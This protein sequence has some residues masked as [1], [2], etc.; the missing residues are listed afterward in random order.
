MFLRFLLSIVF[1][2]ASAPHLLSVPLKIAIL[3]DIHHNN[4]QTNTSP[5]FKTM[6]SK[7][8]SE[9][10]SHIIVTGDLI[11]R[12]VGGIK[13]KEVYIQYF[14]ELADALS[15]THEQAPADRI[16]LAIG[17]HDFVKV[18]KEEDCKSILSEF[19]QYLSIPENYGPEKGLL[20]YDFAVQLRA[21]EKHGPPGYICMPGLKSESGF[22]SLFRKNVGLQ[23]F[24]KQVKEQR[25]YF[26][27]FRIGPYKFRL[28]HVPLY[29]RKKHR[30]P[31][32]ETDTHFDISGDTHHREVDYF[33]QKPNTNSLGLRWKKNP[34]KRMLPGTSLIVG[35]SPIHLNPGSS[36]GDSTNEPEFSY[37]LI[38]DSQ[39]TI[40]FL[41]AQDHTLIKLYSMG[42]S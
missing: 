22:Y 17:N 16:F 6:V 35:K 39:K 11:D 18:A 41:N 32:P 42:S 12:S 33:F 30:S 25:N 24:G 26:T 36:G 9:G 15:Q 38:D 23:S 5:L 2:F 1:L 40:R 19:R 37:I 27:Y 3:G 7:I 20:S 10:V 21:K 13:A 8:K 29:D 31:S 14:K 4:Q 34:K 28:S